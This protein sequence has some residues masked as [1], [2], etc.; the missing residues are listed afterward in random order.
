METIERSVLQTMLAGGLFPAPDAECEAV[1]ARAMALL[2]ELNA[3]PMSQMA[4]RVD[5][6]QRALIRYEPGYLNS[7]VRWQYGHLDIDKGCFFN[8]DCLFLDNAKITFGPFVAVGPRTQFITS[9]HPLRAAD[10]TALDAN[11]NFA[12]VWVTSAPITVEESVWIGAGVIVLPGVT[13]GARSMIGAGS[14][15]TK[16]VPPDSLAYGNP[17][18]V[19]RQIV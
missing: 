1:E 12:H 8:W 9:G 13:I 18:R 11:G 10:R 7:P 17:C 3:T 6:L 15:V 16:S 2:D 19:V 14:V 5:I 4:K